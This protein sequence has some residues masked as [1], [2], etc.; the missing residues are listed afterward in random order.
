MLSPGC[1]V[2]L[3]EVFSIKNKSG[4]CE[5]KLVTMMVTTKTNGLT[6][7]KLMPIEATYDFLNGVRIL[8]TISY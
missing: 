7:S 6:A 5:P 8:K 1:R 4:F 2:F 3:S